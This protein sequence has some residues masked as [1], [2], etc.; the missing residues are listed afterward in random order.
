MKKTKIF[1]II[2]TAVSC[3]VWA[4]LLWELNDRV[5]GQ[6]LLE[7]EARISANGDVVIRDEWLGVYMGEARIGF[8]NLRLARSADEKEFEV[9]AQAAVEINVAGSAKKVCTMTEATVDESLSLKSFRFAFSS[10]LSRFIVTGAMREDGIGV[11]LI[12]GES[13]TVQNL[14]ASDFPLPDAPVCLPETVRFHVLQNRLKPGDELRLNLLDPVTVSVRE[15]VVKMG[16]EETVDLRGEKVLAFPVHQDFGSIQSTLWL[17][18]DGEVVQERGSMGGIS[19]TCQRQDKAELVEVKEFEMGPDIMAQSRI[20]VGK[21]DDARKVRRLRARLKTFR[22][23]DYPRH[24]MTILSA[25]NDEVEVEIKAGP[26]LEIFSKEELQKHLEPTISMPIQ[27]PKIVRTAR[28]LLR[29]SQDPNG[30]A[31]RLAQWVYGAV[32]KQ[33]ILSFPN[34]VQVLETLQGDCNEHAVL[35]GALARAAGIPTRLC[36]GLLYLDGFFY[37]HAWNEVYLD[38]SWVSVD[39]TL[40]QGVKKLGFVDATHIK[41]VEGE[42]DQQVALLGLI[43]RLKIEVIDFTNQEGEV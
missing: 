43:G 1:L 14:P 16:N 7:L 34:A 19:L 15:V 21:I 4:G 40:P 11:T 9:D 12:A 41:L 22:V 5:S 24:G 32:Q 2:F 33:A 23:E 28:R 31:A 37:Y 29:G 17:D 38:D 35:Y 18:D 8:T 25:T 42:L 26:K 3:V 27:D 6:T 36:A 30:N 39:T 10:S 20:P 13:S